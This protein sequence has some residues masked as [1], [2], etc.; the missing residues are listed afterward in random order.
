MFAN[1]IRV[2]TGKIKIAHKGSSYEVTSSKLQVADQTEA[3]FAWSG[4]VSQELLS[5]SDEFFLQRDAWYGQDTK[6]QLYM[7]R[8]RDQKQGA[9]STVLTVDE[10]S[11]SVLEGLS[12]GNDFGT[13]VFAQHPESSFF[14]GH[15]EATWDSSE[16]VNT[17][18]VV[19]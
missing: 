14:I 1:S 3:S 4:A 15:Y 9:K 6:G 18:S 10:F 19:V 11:S 17:G 13:D 12:L 8:L 2:A 16:P 7:S 5:V